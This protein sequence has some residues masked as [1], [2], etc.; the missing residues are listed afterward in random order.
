MFSLGALVCYK[1]QHQAKNRNILINLLIYNLLSKIVLIIFISILV[2]FKYDFF[3]KFIHFGCLQTGKL[4]KKSILPNMSQSHNF[5]IC[6]IWMTFSILY[7]RLKAGCFRRKN[8][9]NLSC[10]FCVSWFI[11]MMSIYIYA[12]IHKAEISIQNYFFQ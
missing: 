9:V 8:N 10:F 4:L 6:F 12:Y 1:L 2:S 3:L 11:N 7:F 5:R